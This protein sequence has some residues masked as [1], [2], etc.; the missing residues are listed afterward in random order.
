MKK[1]VIM[2]ISLSLI[3]SLSACTSKAEEEWHNSEE[4][5]ELMDDMEDLE[6]NIERDKEMI[7]H[8]DEMWDDYEDTFGEID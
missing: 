4:Y 3:F 6:E 7:E 1:I 2:L 8:L 5:K